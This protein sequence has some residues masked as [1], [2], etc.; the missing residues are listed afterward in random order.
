[1]NQNRENFIFGNGQLIIV[2]VCLCLARGQKVKF[3]LIID[4][5][6]KLLT[7]FLFREFGRNKKTF[8]LQSRIAS[9]LI[10]LLENIIDLFKNICDKFSCIVC[11]PF[12]ASL[13]L[14]RPF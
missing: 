1:L 14:P 8:R 10:D 9:F 5:L 3:L 2:F 11:S 4:S 6:T 7:N 13:R 12:L